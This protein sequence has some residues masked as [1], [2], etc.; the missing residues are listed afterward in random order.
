MPF[1]MGT[2]ECDMHLLLDAIK[3]FSLHEKYYE[4]NPPI[5]NETL[6]MN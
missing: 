3:W 2:L 6:E 1:P 4:N 5:V